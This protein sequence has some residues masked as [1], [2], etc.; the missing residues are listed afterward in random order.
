[1][2][3]SRD[4]RHHRVKKESLH[5]ILIRNLLAVLKILVGCI[6]LVT[7]FVNFVVRP[8]RVSGVSMFPTIK[9][10][11]FA[12]TNAFEARFGN[13]E[14]GDIVV[15]HEKKYLH[16]MVVKRVIALPGDRIFAHNDVVYVNGEPIVEPYLDNEWSTT[17]R[18][19]E[20]IFTEDFNEV[21]LGTDEYWLMGDNRINSIDSRHFGPCD[22]DEIK[23]K[24]IFILFPF[25]RFLTDLE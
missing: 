3:K 17:I 19:S 10:G 11:E 14:R 9:D 16:A 24:S 1:M 15:A 7:L 21:I 5:S 23:G 22:R 4:H 20:A 13:I 25:N 18:D 8:V 6:I 12:I 2:R